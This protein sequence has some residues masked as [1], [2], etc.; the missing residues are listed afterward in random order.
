[1]T[2]HVIFD[3]GGVL[4]KHMLHLFAVKCFSIDTMQK[5]KVTERMFGALMAYAFNDMEMSPYT[6]RQWVFIT[7]GGRWLVTIDEDLPNGVV[8]LATSE[9][10]GELMGELRNVVD[11]SYYQKVAA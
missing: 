8:A 11:Y 5:L 10:S 3:A 1:M 9:S 6:D 4:N 2:P 7:G